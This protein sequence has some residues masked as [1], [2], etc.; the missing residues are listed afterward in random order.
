MNEDELKKKLTA[1]EYSVLRKGGT[2]APFSGELLNKKESG[3]Y[4]CKVC[5]NELFSS[6][7]K[8]E[9]KTP[10]LMGWPSFNDAIPESVEFKEDNTLGTHRTEVICAKCKSHLGHVFNADDAK[11]GTHFCVNSVCLD[12][13]S[14]EK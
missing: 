5:G 8:F 7:T 13:K 10:G 1:E 14:E 6:D 12:F 3:M 9:S 2:E 11:S 4:T